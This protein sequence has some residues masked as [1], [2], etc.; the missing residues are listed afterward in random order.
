[1]LLLH[2]SNGHLSPIDHGKPSFLKEFES[3]KPVS[4]KRVAV[5]IRDLLVAQ[6]DSPVQ[7]KFK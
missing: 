3:W 2:S 7:R 6:N 5:N 4:Y 1:M